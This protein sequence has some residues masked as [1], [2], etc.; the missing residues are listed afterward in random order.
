MSL[1]AEINRRN[2]TKVAVLYIVATWLILQVADVGV[3]LLELPDWVGKTVFLLLALGF[4]LALI[5]SWVY[6]LTPEGLKREKEIDRSQSITHETGR[7]INVL[8][9]VLLVLAIGAAD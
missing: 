8:I 7:K 3:S 9:V 4:P 5:F 1:I 6:E 2:V